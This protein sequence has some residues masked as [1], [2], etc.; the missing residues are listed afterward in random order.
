M[1][2]P[3][4][5]PPPSP[6]PTPPS[7]ETSEEESPPKNPKRRRRQSIRQRRSRRREDT[8]QLAVEGSA[9]R[10]SGASALDELRRASGQAH[11]GYLSGVNT[12]TSGLALN[13]VSAAVESRT[14]DGD[15][16][17]PIQNSVSSEEVLH[18]CL[19]RPEALCELQWS[20]QLDPK[21][22]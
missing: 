14:G 13:D 3:P 15:G 10:C 1:R 22:V 9:V 20:P 5:S 17:A 11:N 8:P 7:E 6:P 18:T 21:C 12:T 2:L 16:T 19:P 4:D